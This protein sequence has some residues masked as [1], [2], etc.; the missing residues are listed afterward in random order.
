ME[1]WFVYGLIAAVLIAAT[2]MFTRKFTDKYTITEHLLYYYFLC[3]IFIGLYAVY[4]KYVVGERVKLIHKE[5]LWKYGLVAAVSV[6]I[7]SPCQVM[8]IR[9]S[10][11]PG[12]AKAVVNLNTLFLFFMGVYFIKSEKITTKQI[13]GIVASIGGIYLIM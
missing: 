8:S 12:Q 10:K 1:M 11:N 6:I 13:L 3:G 5:D 2:D 7:I 4:K 9:G